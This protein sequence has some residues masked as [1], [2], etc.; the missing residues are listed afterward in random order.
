MSQDSLL[1]YL[2]TFFSILALVSFAFSPFFEI[3][4]IEIQ[5]L[6]VLD[7]DELDSLITPYENKNILLL[8]SRKLDRELKAGSGYIEGVKIKKDFPDKLVI[9][10]DERE[11]VAMIN[12]NGKY[13]SFSSSGFIVEEGLLKKRVSVPEISGLGYSLKNNRISFSKILGEIV[14]ALEK[15]SMERRSGITKI[16]YDEEKNILTADTNAYQVYFGQPEELAD[17]FK[18][19]ESVFRKIEEQDL[20]V[21]YVDLRILKKPVIKLK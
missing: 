5:G 4:S 19:L 15:L 2:I 21:E 20:N 14:Q 9:I 17:K 8:D 18:V 6:N 7:E 12:N 3:K 11:P 1:A 13:I 16:S 10:I